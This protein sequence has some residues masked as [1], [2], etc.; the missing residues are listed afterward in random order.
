VTIANLPTQ[1]TPA[2]VALE[3]IPS[4]TFLRA[5][6]RFLIRIVSAVV[7]AVTAIFNVDANVI[8]TFKPFRRAVFSI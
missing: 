1:N 5:F 6:F 2:I 7:D 4:A 8:V 3:S